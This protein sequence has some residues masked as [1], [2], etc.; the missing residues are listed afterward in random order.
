MNKKYTKKQI[1]KAIKH[2]ESILKNIDESNNLISFL[3]NVYGNKTVISKSMN[4]SINTKI[5]YELFDILNE[6]LFDNKLSKC[7]ICCD[8]YDNVISKLK[9]RKSNI[10]TNDFY[11]M[12]DTIAYDEDLKELSDKL[13]YSDNLILINTSLVNNSNFIFAC[14]GL[15]HEMLHLYDQ[16][17]GEKSICD[18]HW[19][20][21]KVKIDSHT[22][23]TFIKIKRKAND[24][25]LTVI[26]KSNGLS[27]SEL[28]SEAYLN[29]MNSVVNDGINLDEANKSYDNDKTILT[30][31]I[32]GL[33]TNI[34]HVDYV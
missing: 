29:L 2:W 22:T 26:D 19:L 31:K 30:K 10:P 15:C 23:P 18:K 6:H 21:Y 5:A 14:S 16:L 13:T 1:I 28:N 25:G 8:T 32:P 9:I 7:D 20:L 12:F 4:F 33:G 34:C 24:M 11:G 17:Y 27:F 3:S